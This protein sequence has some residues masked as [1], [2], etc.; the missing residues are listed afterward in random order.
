MRFKIKMS[1][2]ISET[3]RLYANIKKHKKELKRLQRHPDL[4]KKNVLIEICHL[5]IE[6]DKIKL[7]ILFATNS[8]TS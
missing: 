2:Y 4:R 5:K 7:K 1:Y 3:E 8:R 6:R